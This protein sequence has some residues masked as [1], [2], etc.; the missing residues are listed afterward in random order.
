MV[1]VTGLEPVTSTMSTLRSSQL[2]YTPS[3]SFEE[4]KYTPAADIVKSKYGIF[5]KII[6]IFC[7]FRFSGSRRG[8][9]RSVS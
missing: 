6:E 9:G 2:S 4:L 3:G 7:L 5:W 8:A 1:G